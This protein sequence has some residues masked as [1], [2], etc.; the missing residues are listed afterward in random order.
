MHL[1]GFIIRIYHDGRS[2]KRQ[3]SGMFVGLIFSW[4]KILEQKV[5]S[6]RVN[7]LMKMLRSTA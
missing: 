2:P 7:K 4:T 5:V 6:F 1:F 3:R